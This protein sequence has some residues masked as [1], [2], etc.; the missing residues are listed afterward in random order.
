MIFFAPVSA[1][2]VVLPQ[3]VVVAIQAPTIPPMI[4]DAVRAVG[5]VY[6]AVP[7][8]TA[9]SL[10]VRVVAGAQQLFNDTFRVT[11]N[12]GANYQESRM[13]APE[14]VCSDVGYYDSQQRSSLTISVSLRAASPEATL[15]NVSVSW[16]RPIAAT[17]CVGNGSREV[18]LSQTVP[19][20]PGQTVTIHGDAGLAI[21]LGR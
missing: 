3:P 21:T 11:G 19:L 18:Q 13:Q 5:G 6:S 7:P 14:V 2:P 8:V 9:I 17:S 12:A 4:P 15:V 1:H 16:Q 10:H 20:G